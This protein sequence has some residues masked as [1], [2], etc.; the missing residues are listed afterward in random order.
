MSHFT[1]FHEPESVCQHRVDIAING[2][3]LLSLITSLTPL[4]AIIHGDRKCPDCT[5]L[6]CVRDGPAAG[7]GDCVF[8]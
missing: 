2:L 6:V 3:H 7:A 1:G 4:R 8:N 5:G